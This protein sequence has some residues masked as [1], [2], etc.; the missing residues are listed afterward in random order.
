MISM[1]FSRQYHILSQIILSLIRWYSKAIDSIVC[2][3]NLKHYVPALCCSSFGTH[4]KSQFQWEMW[5]HWSVSLCSLCLVILEVILQTAVIDGA[6]ER[7]NG[8]I[9]SPFL[10]SSLEDNCWRMERLEMLQ[11]HKTLAIKKSF[12]FTSRRQAWKKSTGRTSDKLIETKAWD[13][14]RTLTQCLSCSLASI[15]SAPVNQN[16][17]IKAAVISAVEYQKVA[18]F[19][20]FYFV[21]LSKSSWSLPK[22]CCR[23]DHWQTK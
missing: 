7:W 22:S 13:G 20:W 8:A 18:N 3:D 6:Y 11:V 23:K 10:L 4:S 5:G 9:R 16:P 17:N 14:E 21:W 1:L 12:L 15:K 2:T 19:F